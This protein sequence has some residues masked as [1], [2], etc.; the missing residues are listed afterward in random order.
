[1]ADNEHLLHASDLTRGEKLY[2]YRNRIGFSQEQRCVDLGVGFAEYR[3][4]EVDSET[5]KP[6]YISI[7]AMEP[8]E[9]YMIFRRR[10][11]MTKGE[12]A[13]AVG[14]SVEWLRQ[15]EQGRAPIRRLEE[16]W[17]AQA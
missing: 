13:E 15:M 7:G 1:M 5:T 4:M 2:L 10:A 6:P 3:A 14:C 12:V 11:G 8:R 9:S 17:K 16:Y